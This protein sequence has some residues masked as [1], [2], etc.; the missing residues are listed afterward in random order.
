[1]AIDYF[2]QIANLVRSAA[3]TT[4]MA[5]ADAAREFLADNSVH[6]QGAWWAAHANDPYYTAEQMY[7]TAV[8][9]PSAETAELLCGNMVNMFQGV[10]YYLG[11]Q[12][13][14]VWLYSDDL[15]FFQGHTYNEVYDAS[16][17]RWVIQDAD[18]NVCYVDR[19]TGQKIGVAEMMAADDIDHFVPMNAD[20]KGWA[21]TGAEPL[22]LANFYGAQVVSSDHIL[23]VSADSA[24]PDLL[25]DIS[26]TLSGVYTYTTDY[27][28]GNPA[29]NH[30]TD[31]NAALVNGRWTLSGGNGADYLSYD[32]QWQ[33]PGF[34]V[35]AGNGGDD[36]LALR[37]CAGQLYGNAG[38]DTLIGS[39]FVDILSGSVGDDYMS[40]AGGADQYILQSVD[41]FNDVIDSFGWGADKLVFMNCGG[42]GGTTATLSQ[43]EFDFRISQTI[44]SDGLY[45][46]YDIDGDGRKDGGV[47]LEGRTSS[48]GVNDASFMFKADP[49]AGY[50]TTATTAPAGTGY[51]ELITGTSASDKIIYT[52][53]LGAQIA[54]S[55][56]GTGSGNDYL[57][58]HSNANCAL[59]G[60]DGND[61]IFGGLGDDYIVGG[62][63]N[64]Y[65]GGRAG[66][67]CFVFAQGCGNDTIE[68]FDAYDTLA[69]HGGGSFAQS[70]KQSWAGDN[71]VVGI[72]FTRDGIADATVTMLHQTAMTTASDWVFV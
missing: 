38:N 40:G 10:A 45:V 50:N 30:L 29:V 65:L 54:G 43:R 70:I 14:V 33:T 44:E 22:R 41:G 1:M 47:L 58:S 5:L 68:D 49:M 67:D 48:I 3:S 17:G 72:D 52:G 59:Y 62:A 28:T 64:D 12:S 23:Y 31:D 2:Q 11:L 7:K 39:Q 71:L 16:L 8:G 20:V 9:D 34:A 6:A 42:T 19:A 26:S 18:Y 60:H 66:Y 55:A 53:T 51:A 69:V 24:T 57:Q 4:G 36:V 56:T 21:D 61:V 46:S 25:A 27:E 63:G 13:R 37:W 32:G 35:L 15:G